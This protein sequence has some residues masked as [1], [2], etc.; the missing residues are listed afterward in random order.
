MSQLISPSSQPQPIAERLQ[1]RLLKP[2]H[3]RLT[4]AQYLSLLLSIIAIVPL[5]ATI[6]SIEFFL[7]PALIAQVGTSLQQAAQK[8]VQLIDTYLVERIND[9]QAQSQSTPVK[10]LLEGNQ[11]SRNQVF[12]ALF[13]S[14]HRDVANY[15]SWSILDLQGNP[16]ISY[17][18]TPQGHGSNKYM[19]LPGALQQLQQS[20]RVLLSDVFYDATRS[21]AS[22]DLYARVVND[23]FKV[24]GFVR[25]S[26]GLQ[27][28]W[29][30]V[31]SETQ[32]N[33]TGS[34]G[35]I[36]DQNKVRIAY[37]DPNPLASTRPV[38]LFKAVAPLSTA[39]QERV[40]NED[41]YGNST[42]PLRVYKDSTLNDI[43][44]AAHPSDHFEINPMEQSQTAFEAVRYR[45]AIMPWDYF[46]LKPQNVITGI[47]DQQL[48]TILII[49]TCVLI[50]AVT[51]GLLVSQ[52]IA[53]PISHSVVTLRKSS[54]SLKN[55]AS[56]E[57]VIANEQEWMVDASKAG[58]QSV[59]YYTN[60][61]SIAAKRI[62]T[63]INDLQQNR[64]ALDS[65]K[66][67]KALDDIH[68]AAE[69][70]VRATHHQGTMNEKLKTTIR[71]TTQA[72]GQLTKGAEATEDA[73]TQLERIVEALTSVVGAQEMQKEAE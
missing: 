42:T 52:R 45:S 16:V 38:Q 20:S 14:Q 27:R 48:L 9:V 56:E 43:V 66:L 67:Q 61:N 6:G 30:P 36:L 7:R 32:E 10:S 46:I 44:S 13:T 29:A 73:A 8:R 53:L 21:V 28:I 1:K 60:A 23:S 71:V 37:T 50:L 51:L 58:L 19:I 63:I 34:Y 12:S 47:V 35:F 68:N 69:Y 54:R 70:I 17:P 5:L 72:T 24:L 64:R 41:L 33:G 49:V 57:H 55:L 62:T 4:L 11:G 3:Y 2:M 59:Q 39:M 22:I 31:N 26:L 65:G 25:A 18:T 15:I 40:K